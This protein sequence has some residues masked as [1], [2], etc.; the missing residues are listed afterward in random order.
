MSIIEVLES[1]EIEVRNRKTTPET[2]HVYERKW[3]DWRITKK[4]Q[5]FQKLDSNTA[6]FVVDLKPNEVK[7]VSYT[8]DTKW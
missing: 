2:V 7:T 8:V 1:F 6:D 4:S 3:G 5:D